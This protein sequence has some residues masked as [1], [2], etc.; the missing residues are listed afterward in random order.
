MRESIRWGVVGSG[1]IARRRTIPEG[2]APASNA[3]L[4]GVYGTNSTTNA[5]VAKE[6]GATPFDSLKSLLAADIDAVYIATPVYLHATQVA[7]C[8]G[9]RKHVLC[10]KPL[11]LRVAEAQTLVALAEECKLQLGAG[12]MMRFHSQHQEALKII[13]AGKLG[14]PVYARAQLS[15]WYPPLQGAWRQNASQAGGGSLADMGVHCL[16]LLEMLFG[17]VASLNCQISRLVHG[18]ETEDSA[19]V[20]LTFENGAMG[21]VDTFFCVPDESSKNV[22]ELYGSEGSILAKGTIGQGCQGEM[23]FRAR[24]QGKG[25][26]AQQTRQQAD[27]VDLRPPPVNMYRAEIEEFSQALLDGRESELARGRGLRSQKLLQACYESAQTSKTVQI[28]K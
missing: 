25:Y 3:R 14:T 11:T 8:L 23:V 24:P 28:A 5:E 4:V 2:I 19:I 6:F 12:L 17:P 10:E 15:C 13:A 18:Y 7:Q 22:L 21:T 1:G 26:D 9:A 27:G 16:D 20:M